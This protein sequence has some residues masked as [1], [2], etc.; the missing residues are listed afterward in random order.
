MATEADRVWASWAQAKIAQ[1]QQECDEAREAAG[2]LFWLQR[3]CQRPLDT[4][5]WLKRYPW[6]TLVEPKQQQDHH[7][8]RQGD[9]DEQNT[10]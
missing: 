3:G 1:L 5:A 6:L 2:L 4:E 10:F 9:G 7:D 8:D